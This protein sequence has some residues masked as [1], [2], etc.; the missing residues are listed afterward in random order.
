M[1]HVY[2]VCFSTSGG[3]VYTV[4]PGTAV[5]DTGALRETL[6]VTVYGG[7]IVQLV[8]TWNVITM[9]LASSRTRFHVLNFP[10]YCVVT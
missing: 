5:N 1:C 10:L 9:I 6:D 7:S 4:L 2:V 3:V 8:F